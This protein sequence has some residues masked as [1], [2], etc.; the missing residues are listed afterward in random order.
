MFTWLSQAQ[1]S[2]MWT[3]L[4]QWWTWLLHIAIQLMPY[5]IAFTIILLI[6]WLIKNW[7]KLSNKWSTWYK[8][9][10]VDQ[11][12]WTS[13]AWKQARARS[14]LHEMNVILNDPANEH[15]YNSYWEWHKDYYLWKDWIVYYKEW[16]VKDEENNWVADFNTDSWLDY[17]NR[18][19]K[20]FMRYYKDYNDTWK[21]TYW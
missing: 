9:W 1:I 13:L 15:F 11:V 14:Q 19:H 3:A 4:S 12:F 21:S 18:K 2:G 6:F 7:S 16:W 20:D 17:I 8:K 10:T 5:A